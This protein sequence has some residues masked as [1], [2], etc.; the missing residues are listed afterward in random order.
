MIKFYFATRNRYKLAEAQN[1]LKRYDVCLEPTDIVKLEVQSE[2][3]EDIAINAAIDAYR[4]LRKPVVVEDSGLFI[5]ALNGFPGPYSSFVYK[6]IGLQGI[7]KLMA[8]VA[9][10]RA[11]FEAVVA[12]AIDEDDVHVFKGVVE[13][14]I[15]TEIRGNKGFGFDPIFIPLEGDGRTFAEMDIDEKNRYSHRGRAFDMLG[16]W[17][18]MNRD[19][20]KYILS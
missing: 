18:S 13:G 9:D 8:D 2:S 16:R 12:L 15:S 5:E 20:L 17:I 4:Q 14:V 19:K 10:R 3:L 11:R 6:T 7:L 1:V